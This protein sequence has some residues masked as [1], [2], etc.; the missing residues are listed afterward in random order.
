MK[1]WPILI[2]LTLVALSSHAQTSSTTG[3]TVDEKKPTVPA[4]QPKHDDPYFMISWSGWPGAEPNFQDERVL[5]KGSLVQCL[6]IGAQS[7]PSG[8]VLGYPDGTSETVLSH[9]DT[10]IA[11]GGSITMH[12]QGQDPTC[13][14]LQTNQVQK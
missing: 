12:C 2:L 10:R 3:T 14:K 5:R 6:A 8:C 7:V 1:S 13:C 4:C 11:K 9:H